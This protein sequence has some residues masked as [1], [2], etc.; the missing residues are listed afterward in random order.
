VRVPFRL[1]RLQ[2]GGAT[3][4]YA[5]TAR[6]K[7]AEFL[8]ALPSAPVSRVWGFD[9]GDPIDR[10]YIE[11]FLERHRAD[12]RG[13]VLEFADSTYTR[14]FGGERVRNSDVLEVVAGNPKA[15]IVADLSRPNDLASERFDCI[16]CTQ[17]LQMIF[18]VRAA[19]AQLH[20]LLRPQGVLLVTGAGISKVG[21]HLGIDP[22]GE[23]WHFTAQSMRF[24]LAE[25]F[26]RDELAVAA[27]GN[28]R[29]ATAF[30]YGVAAQE[31]PP[32]ALTRNDRGYEVLVAARAVKG[33]RA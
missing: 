5:A 12:I 22:W 30:L 21:R 33:T 32:D 31:L 19:V 26:A 7:D 20:R 4:W 11:R 18:D 29:A 24:L 15:T 25:A 3:R 23:Y 28:V 1:R 8:S 27:Y 10:F 2:Q 14:R 6:F 16:I 17:V 9:R 13:D